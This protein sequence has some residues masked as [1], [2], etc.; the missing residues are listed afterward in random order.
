MT[1]RPLAILGGTFDPVHHGHLR[2]AWEAAEQLDAEVRL[3]PAH[4]P[5]HRPAPL[6]DAAHRVALLRA[7]L[8]GQDRLG[9]DTRELDRQGPSYT[10]DTL[11]ALRAEIGPTRPLVLLVGTDAFAHLPSWHR[12]R[13]LFELAHIGVLTR[14]G[15]AP[16]LHWDLA[17]EVARRRAHALRGPAGDVIDIAIT[18][19]DIAATAIRD[20]FA[21]G[22][23]PRYLLPAVFFEDETLLAPYRPAG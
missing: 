4:V 16:T 14:P 15:S 2:A 22:R 20:A 12:W 1:A 18:P 11:A 3:V 21:S 13:E 6:A 19:L 8:A 7:A 17:T 10:V 5:P 9:L 23:E